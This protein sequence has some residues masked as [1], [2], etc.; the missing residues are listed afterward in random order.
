[1]DLTAGKG[2]KVKQIS[3]KKIKRRRT[4]GNFLKQEDYLR[5][6]L[7]SP[8]PEGSPLAEHS[9]LVENS[10]L[11]ENSPLPGRPSPENFPLAA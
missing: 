4:Q 5:R 10:P 9:P 1:M 11:A 3:K 2:R 7:Q 6:V 8:L